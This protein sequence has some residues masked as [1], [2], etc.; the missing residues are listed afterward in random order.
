M[1]TIKFILFFA[2]FTAIF[3]G[4]EKTDYSDLE[5]SIWEAEANNV[6]FTLRFLDEFTSTIEVVGKDVNSTSLTN[7]HWRYGSEYDSMW[8]YFFM[9]NLDVENSPPYS[10]TIENKKLYLQIYNDGIDT[11]C[12][13]KIK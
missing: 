9:Y 13:K 3:A 7:F 5:G 2:L 10:G 1:K 8:G 4:C 12:F 6:V 11:L